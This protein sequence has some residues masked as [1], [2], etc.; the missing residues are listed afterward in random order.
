M[1]NDIAN[2]IVA[3]THVIKALIDHEG[4][5][6][7]SKIKP[8]QGDEDVPCVLETMFM[9]DKDQ[10][11]IKF[12]TNVSKNDVETLLWVSRAIQNIAL[13]GYATWYDHNVDQWGTKWDA[14]SQEIEIGAVY[15]QAKFFTAWATP[16]PIF[17][18]LSAMFPNEQIEVH[19]A[20]EAHEHRNCGMVIYQNGKA[21]SYKQPFIHEI[22]EYTD[23]MQNIAIADDLVNVLRSFR[24][25]P[26]LN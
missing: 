10:P 20:D 8:W 21:T 18:A 25:L 5:V 16:T 6:S 23:A 12:P 1:A 4:L 14:Y 11:Y 24:K 17:E 2:V 26:F 19:Y 13:T 22:K 3:P 7:F 15:S 9:I